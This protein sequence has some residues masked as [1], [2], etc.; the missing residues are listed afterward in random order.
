[1]RYERYRETWASRDVK[2]AADPSTRERK[3]HRE[4]FARVR[5]VR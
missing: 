3:R 5:L 1:M 4:H 2:A